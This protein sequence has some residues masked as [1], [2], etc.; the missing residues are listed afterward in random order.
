ME[1]WNFVTTAKSTTTLGTTEQTYMLGS[2]TDTWG[3]AW[4]PSE[5]TNANFRVRIISVASSTARDFSL[6]WAAVRVTYR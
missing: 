1:R 3:R 2:A 6:D 5:S 4:L